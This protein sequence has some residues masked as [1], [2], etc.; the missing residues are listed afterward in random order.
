MKKILVTGG[1]G[2]IGSATVKELIKQGYDVVVIDNLSNGNMNLVD[3]NAIFYKVDLIEKEKLKQVFDKH[4]FDFIIH[5]AA[6]K[7]VE[8]SMHNLEKYSCNI[9]GLINLLDLSLE[10]DVKKRIF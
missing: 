3:K 1:A 2:Y 4:K 8:E 6:Y 9:T 10:Y 5:F 7:S